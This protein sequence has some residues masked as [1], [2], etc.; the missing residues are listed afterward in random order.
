MTILKG[1]FTSIWDNHVEISTPA[2]LDTVT[3]EVST[4]AVEAG[5]VDV[6]EEEYFTDDKGNQYPICPECHEY[7]VVTS[8]SRGNWSRLE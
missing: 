1:T 5:D 7:I 4:E 2:E 6:L 8:M 3:G